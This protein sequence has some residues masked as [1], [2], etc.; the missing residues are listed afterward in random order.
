MFS[1]RR[2]PL[3]VWHHAAYRLA[4]PGLEPARGLDLRRADSA[5]FYLLHTRT[6][7]R[8]LFRSPAPISFID[9]ARIHTDA[10]L[11][12]LG[13]PATL[14][15]VF[16]LDAL[17]VPV[18]ELLQTV[19]LACGGTLEAARE[20]LTRGGPTM[21]LLG[22][23]H[24][25]AP[26]H[27]GALCPVN[28]VAVAIAVLRA[29]GCDG[30]IA[31]L[32]LDAH[33]PDGT[34]ACLAS[35]PRTWIGS[36]SGVHG[37]PLPGVDETVLPPGAGDAAYLEAL[38]AL[39]QRMPPA[40]LC[41][42]LAGGD[43]LAGDARGGLGL[44]MQGARGRD[45][46]VAEALRERPSVWL[47]GGGYHEGAW[48]VLAGTALAVARHSR[49][50]VPATF[51]ALGARFAAIAGELSPEALSRAAGDGGV[52]GEW[53]LTQ[54]DL[55]GAVGLPREH[56]V[57]LLGFYTAAG[58]E[59]GFARYGLLAHIGRLG[60]GGLRVQLD[61][62]PPGDRL[63]LFGTAAGVE[64]LLVECIV[65]RTSL[66]GRDVLFVHWLT[67][68]NPR[69]AFSDARHP[70]PGQEVPGL[71]LAREADEML[72]RIATRLEL[73]GVAFS[74]AQL[75]VAAV[76]RIRYRF[77]DPRR[78][79]R[80]QALLRDL[81]ELPFPEATR[82]M[83]EGRVLCHRNGDPSGEPYAWEPDPMI[84]WATREPGEDPLELAE[85]AAVRFTVVP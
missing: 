37:G 16:S 20:A 60:Y 22:G 10:L 25:A 30:R 40:D 9:L 65:E 35:D 59:H 71:G 62:H 82:A 51:D 14:A 38:D 36:L 34:A 50:T 11:E 33:P 78:E 32:D 2:T 15:R 24:H 81:A 41:F 19:R 46:R 74:P 21:N 29:E 58:I 56:A 5:A 45:L 17:D 55:D 43:V 39:L 18:E 66:A 54:E 3:P 70:L 28:D 1:W 23:F 85:A 12:S 57:R 26:D 67:M 84:H 6:V 44:T 64:H 73:A 13:D 42:V 61:R 8:D 69:A 27:A 79:G 83:A 75:H 53:G 47:P 31:I 49:R 7:A 63:R 77:V 4:L 68:R 52:E 76:A 72:L 48:R 80:F